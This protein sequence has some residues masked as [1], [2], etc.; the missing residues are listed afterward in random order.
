MI[1]ESILFLRCSQK[2]RLYDPWPC[3]CEQ[4]RQLRE[5]SSLVKPVAH[6]GDWVS[7]LHIVTNSYT[8]NLYCKHA[9]SC[10][11]AIPT[12]YHYIFLQKTLDLWINVKWQKSILFAPV[13]LS[14]FFAGYL[15]YLYCINTVSYCKD[16]HIVGRNM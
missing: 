15:Q 11:H 2:L 4:N 12:F 5:L 1:T 9:I 14:F 16:C 10:N 13:C 3:T 6:T 8:V 7:S